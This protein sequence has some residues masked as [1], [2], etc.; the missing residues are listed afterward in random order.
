MNQMGEKKQTLCPLT[1]NIGHS[2]RLLALCP[3]GAVGVSLFGPPWRWADAS[4]VHLSG[5]EEGHHEGL[6]ILRPTAPNQPCHTWIDALSCRGRQREEYNM[7]ATYYTHRKGLLDSNKCLCLF[8]MCASLPSLTVSIMLDSVS[9]ISLWERLCLLFIP[10]QPL[11]IAQKKHS[12]E[13]QSLSTCVFVCTT[14]GCCVQAHA[15][16]LQQC[17]SS[18][19]TEECASDHRL[20]VNQGFWLPLATGRPMRLSVH[21][22]L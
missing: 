20:V 14:C 15:C 5:F 21:A 3:F 1:C 19:H 22:H 12:T 13:H 17:L 9:H 18:S 6:F 10:C 8:Y 16:A 7:R 11:W 4:Q 2:K